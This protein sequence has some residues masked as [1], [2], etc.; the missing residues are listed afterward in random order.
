[1]NRKI[2]SLSGP[3]NLY[4]ARRAARHANAL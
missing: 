3:P 2:M 1:M 4:D